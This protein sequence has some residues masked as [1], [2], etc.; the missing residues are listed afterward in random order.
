MPFNIYYWSRK[1][2]SFRAFYFFW[3]NQ[4]NTS[5][6]HRPRKKWLKRG[7]KKQKVHDPWN[8]RHFTILFASTHSPPPIP[9]KYPHQ[10]RSLTLVP[11]ALHNSKSQPRRHF[12]KAPGGSNETAC[13]RAQLS[14]SPRGLE[15]EKKA[16]MIREP[17][18]GL[19]PIFNRE[20]HCARA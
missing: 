7:M 10:I 13:A 15:R 3:L 2:R 11:L 20:R 8:H 9:P 5:K 18:A 17:R 12:S 6:R 14:S 19:S 1:A 16:R 4:Y